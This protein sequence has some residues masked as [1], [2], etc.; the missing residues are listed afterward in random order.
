MFWARRAQEQCD[1]TR[2]RGGVVAF[3]GFFGRFNPL[4]ATQGKLVFKKITLR[5]F[6][7]YNLSGE[8]LFNHEF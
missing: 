2:A 3:S 7:R 5:R 6:L 4:G 1:Y 8:Q